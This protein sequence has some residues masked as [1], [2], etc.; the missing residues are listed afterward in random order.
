MR[1]VQLEMACVHQEQHLDYRSGLKSSREVISTP[2]QPF[3]LIVLG[4]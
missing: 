3:L 2:A 4:V 1:Y